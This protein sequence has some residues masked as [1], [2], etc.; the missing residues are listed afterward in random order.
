ME[1]SLNF[2]RHTRN[3]M[4]LE[5]ATRKP[6]A[7]AGGHYVY[8]FASDVKGLAENGHTILAIYPDTQTVLLRANRAPSR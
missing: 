3:L 8:A 6:P 4:W 5:P 1:P 7:E 2:Y